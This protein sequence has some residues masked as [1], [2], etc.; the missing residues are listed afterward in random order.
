MNL[1]YCQKSG[2]K[3]TVLLKNGGERVNKEPFLRGSSVCTHHK[4]SVYEF[5][6]GK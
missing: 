3:V 4:N 6:Y 2:L 1:K 5:G